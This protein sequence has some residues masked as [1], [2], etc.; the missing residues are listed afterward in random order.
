MRR[1]W[2][3]SGGLQTPLLYG[4]IGVVTGVLL[5]GILLVVPGIP[6]V[7]VSGISFSIA[8][9]STLNGTP[10]FGVYSINLSGPASGFP[11]QVPS[12]GS[13]TLTLIIV[14]Q[15]SAAHSITSVSLNAPFV[16][17]ATN[18][19]LPMSWDAGEDGIIV[20]F[21]QVNAPA[22]STVAGSGTINALG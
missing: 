8:Q 5:V 20:V 16:V 4:G 12:G 15:D 22:G 11:I 10:W 17:K 18:P 1:G 6:P 2:R 21:V 7:T 3:G 13:V 14:N 9:G 19:A